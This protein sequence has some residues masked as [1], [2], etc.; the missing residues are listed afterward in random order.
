MTSPSPG[1][2]SPAFTK[3]ISP[4]FNELEETTVPSTFWF[5]AFNL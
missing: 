3:T 4:L 2:H 1:I 5:A